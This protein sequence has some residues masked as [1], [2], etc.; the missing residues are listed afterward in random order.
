MTQMLESF[1]AQNSIQT[2]HH[3]ST[4]RPKE[5]HEQTKK[6]L[7]LEVKR[8]SKIVATAI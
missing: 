8:N 4:A 7:A 3:Q 5:V 2:I 6:K 1:V